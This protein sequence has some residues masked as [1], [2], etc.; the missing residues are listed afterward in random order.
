VATSKEQKAKSASERVSQGPR[1]GSRMKGKN[2]RRFE[3]C[4]SPSLQNLVLKQSETKGM[5]PTSLMKAA[6]GRYLHQE[7]NY[8]NLVFKNLEHSSMEIRAMHA[9]MRRFANGFLH[10][11][12]YWFMTWPD[13]AP[14]QRKDMIEKAY[15]MIDKF[16]KTL[17]KRL[18]HGGYLTDFNLEDIKSLIL[19]SADELDPEEV[20]QLMEDER[21][22]SQE[23]EAK[24][25]KLREHRSQFPG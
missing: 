12:F 7:D 1:I 19:E 6:L 13:T 25:E 21:R 22:A 8:W 2:V 16:S 3:F 17:N 15:L 24:E 14:D 5:A 23:K 11:V 20:H 9:E 4:L 10:F 18:S